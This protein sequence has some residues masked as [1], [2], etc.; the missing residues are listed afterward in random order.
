MLPV[1]WADAEEEHLA[2]ITVR[3]LDDAGQPLTNMQVNVST[4]DRWVPGDNFG[5]DQYKNTSS[6][7]GTNGQCIVKLSGQRNRYGCIAIPSSGYYRDIGLAYVFTNSAKGQWQPWN[8]VITLVLQ[9]VLNPIP[10]YAKRV[11]FYGKMKIPAEGKPLGYD[12]VKGD[13]VAPFGTGSESDFILLLQRAPE[14]E[15]MS[16][17]GTAPRPYKLYDVTLRVTF[18]NGDDGIQSAYTATCQGSALKLSREAP[19]NGYQTNLVKRTFR[20]EGG[21]D[22]SDVH[23]DANYFF[24]VRTKKGENGKIVSALYGKIQG[25]VDVDRHGQVRFTYYLNPTPNDRNLEFD[26]KRNLFTHLKSTE[27]VTAP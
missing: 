4:F 19:E 1:V 17:W 14:R 3:V 6:F 13:W 10:M 23:G 7:T 15:V 16:Y 26:P 11:E 27:Q 12:L 24:R 18:S 9:R 5:R 21:A 8:P 22:H 2:Q 20:K 25:D